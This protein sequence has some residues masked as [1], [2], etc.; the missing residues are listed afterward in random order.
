MH[1]APMKG[2]TVT[3]L[4]GC[5]LRKDT[6]TQSSKGNMIHS[7]IGRGQMFNNWL[8]AWSKGVEEEDERKQ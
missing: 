4:L 6:N 7:S 1:L 2:R 8:G 5:P 3:R